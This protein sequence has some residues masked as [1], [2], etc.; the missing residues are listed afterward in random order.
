MLDTL[1]LASYQPEGKEKQTM[2]PHHI[3]VWCLLI[4]CITILAFTCLTGRSLYEL[5]IR[6]GDKEVAATMAC[7]SK[8]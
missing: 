5:R 4:F 8:R 7:E 6:N 3:I 2:K 1:R